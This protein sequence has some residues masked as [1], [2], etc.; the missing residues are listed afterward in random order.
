MK[1]Y[2]FKGYKE[3]VLNPIVIEQL[4]GFIILES[5]NKLYIVECD[6]IKQLE[7]FKI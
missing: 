5:D 6:S 4:N 1:K 2:L 7:T 3:E